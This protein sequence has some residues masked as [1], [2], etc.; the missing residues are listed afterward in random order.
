MELHHLGVDVGER[1]RRAFALRRTNRAKE[2]GVLVALVGGLTRARSASR[3][4][5]DETVL[6]ADAGFVL[7]PD[8]DGRSRRK[9]GEMRLQRLREVFL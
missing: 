7:E 2:I 1:Q 9:V 4:L 6:L 8:L 3:P 5:P